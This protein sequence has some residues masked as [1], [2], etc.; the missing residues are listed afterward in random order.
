MMNDVTLNHQANKLKKLKQLLEQQILFL[1]GAMGT[2]IQQYNFEEVD[3][4]GDT[5]KNHSKLLKG[6]SD[7]LSITQPDKIQNIHYQFFQAGANI[8]ETNTFSANAISQI[9]YGMEHLVKELNEASVKVAKEA[10]KDFCQTNSDDHP[11]F[12]AGAIGPT[13]QTASLSPD[14]NRPGFRTIYFD[15]FVEAYY[16]QAKI[17]WE[18][19][20]DILLV[21]T[22]FDTL[23]LKAAIFAIKRLIQEK[24]EEIPLS[25]SVTITDSSGRT[26]SGQTIE[27]FWNSVAHAKPLSVGINCALGAQEMR[28]YIE[29]LAKITDTYISCYPNAG[30][31][32]AFG[33]YDQTPEEIASLLESFTQNKWVNII[34]GCCGTTPEHIQAIVNK[35]KNAL[36]RKIKSIK[37]TMRLSGLEPLNLTQDKGFIVIGE[38]TNVMGSPKFRKLIIEEKLDNALSVARQQVENGAN[39]LDIC[40]D[41]AL[42]DSE[43]LMTDFINLIASEPDIARVPIMIDSS[44]WSVIEAGLKCVQGKSIVNSL[45]LKEG[46]QKFKEQASLVQCYGAAMVVMAFDEKGQASTKEDKIKICTRAYNILVNEVRVPPQD[47][48]FDPNILTVA[49]GMEEH[50][51]YALDFIEAISVIKRQCPSARI[52][53]GVS[54]ISFSF[55][56]NNHVREAIHS[57]F[58]YH[59]IS[60]GLDMA[61]VNAGMLAVYE[62]I[63]P[64]RL[65]ELVE[66][67]LLNRRDD[68]TEKLIEYAEQVKSQEGKTSVGLGS[69]EKKEQDEWRK[70]NVEERLSYALVKGIIDHIDK[71][72][73]EARKRLKEPLKVIEGPLMTGMGIVGDLFGQGKM[74]LPQVVKS[75][76]V[77]KKA[78]A[79]LLPYMQNKKQGETNR[80]KFLIATVKGDVHDIGK[81]IVGVVLACN[82]YEVIDL[83]VMVPSEKILSE[84]KKHNVDVIGLSGLITPSLDEM[85]H[86]A[87]EMRR[88]AFDVPLFI[89]GAT[90]SSAHTAIKISEHYNHPVIHVEDASRV[91]N[92]LNK[93][94]GE[95]TKKDFVTKLNVDQKKIRENYQSRSLNKKFLSLKQAREYAFK[96]NWH[97]TNIDQPNQ[98]GIHIFENVD[99]NI[100]SQ[101]I[102]WTPFFLAWELTGRY[103]K[104]LDDQKM[105]E[106]AKILFKDAKIMLDKIIKQK[107]FQA[108]GVIGIFPA[109]RVDDSIQVYQDED[110]KNILETFH[111]LRQQNIK[112]KKQ[113]NF[114][115]ADFIAPKSLNQCDYLGAFAV[116][117]GHG[118][119]QY[120]KKYELENDDYSSI[121]VKALGDRLAEAFAEYMHEQVRKKYW[122]YSA[123][124]R[125]TEAELISEKYRGIR[126]AAGYPACPDHTEK[127]TL[128]NLLDVT[129]N[130]G[131]TLTENFAMMPASSVSG[132]YFGHPDAKYFTVGKLQKDQIENYA[133]IKNKSVE[134][135][136]RWLRPYLTYDTP[137]Q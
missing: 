73:E 20:V 91:T 69:K 37:P 61:I 137:R 125:F 101:Y 27:A 31:P 15:K 128:F 1:D 26:L 97:E 85:V 43:R 41:E 121:M 12:I 88:E 32:N 99:L 35:T 2:M 60:A 77:M 4:R 34:G 130:T 102:D 66:D 118:V 94:L 79:Y 50:N 129:Q 40:F 103:P 86:I 75:A 76:R 44:K 92:L 16:E 110:Q 104:I 124:E 112:Q 93:I 11:C 24:N 7:L 51:S 59:A 135:I 29:E 18:A 108:R 30:L 107:R 52:S 49:T 38:R 72:T 25:I 78:V 122:G 3:F 70:K 90:T 21:E 100:L 131:I 10:I 56:G 105:G 115:L 54:N 120:S 5:F 14:V 28:P 57:A 67:V 119:E 13:N 53:G 39:I 9:D 95:A 17:L 19:N 126:P 81:N 133:K 109:N 36:P 23:N 113:V 117:T 134:E 87:K 58:L 116:T 82:N 80:G 114:A 106:Q 136:E 123:N 89:G 63:S 55:R 65:L 68:S 98:L 64:P 42:L 96:T 84:A 6:N 111:T 22:T 45:S 8:I 46:E 62:N 83:G 127:E 47:I 48:I 74:F 71:D 132:L 33:E